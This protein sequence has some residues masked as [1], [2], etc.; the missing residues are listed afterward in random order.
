MDKLYNLL[1]NVQGKQ[2]DDKN[3]IYY[4]NTHIYINDIYG[5]EEK[6]EL[7]ESDIQRAIRTHAGMTK[8][9]LLNIKHY[10]TECQSEL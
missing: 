1:D 3:W 2:L 4:D 7:C 6:Y 9:V 10:L 8:K 5:N